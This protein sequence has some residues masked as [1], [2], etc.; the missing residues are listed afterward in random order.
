ML[1]NQL[2][3]KK[4]ITFLHKLDTTVLKRIFE[5]KIDL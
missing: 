3:V 1:Y 4:L 5:K 2:A